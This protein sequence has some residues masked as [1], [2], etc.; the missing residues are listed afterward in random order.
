TGTRIFGLMVD[1]LQVHGSAR[2]QFIEQLIWDLEATLRI[3][4]GEEDR[5]GC[6]GSARNRAPFCQ[7]G[8]QSKHALLDSA[9]CVIGS[10]V[11]MAHECIYGTQSI[12]FLLRKRQESIVKVLGP[13]ASNAATNRVR[14]DK[15]GI[16]S[17]F[18]SAA[19][20]TSASFRGVEIAGRARRTSKSCFSI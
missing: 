17:S 4:K 16:H 12:P 14:R 10:V 19:R 11:G 2:N 8:V 13:S 9:R 15:L 1:G 5:I 6:R 7:P 18:P 20:A 3:C